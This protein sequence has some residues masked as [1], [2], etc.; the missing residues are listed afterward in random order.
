[1]LGDSSEFYT[2][3]AHLYHEQGKQWLASLPERVALCAAQWHVTDLSVS[4][5][6]SFNYI[7]M[8][9]RTTDN[10]HVVIKIAYDTD[11]WHQEKIMLERYNGNGCVRLLAYDTTHNALLLEQL[12]S[13]RPLSSLFPYQEN[14]AIEHTVTLMRQLH[15]APVPATD[16]IQ[17]LPTS[18]CWLNLLNQDMANIPVYHL[19]KARNLAQQLLATQ[20]TPVLVHGDLHQGNI[21]SDGNAWRAIDPK[22]AI[23]E[24]AYEV[25]A[26][27]RNPTQLLIEHPDAQTIIT[28]RIALFA[29][30]MQVDRQRIK[31]WSYVQ[32]VL[33]A[34]WRQQDDLE[35]DDLIRVAELIDAALGSSQRRLGSMHALG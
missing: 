25:G 18:R 24:P 14:L 1:M 4:P 32:A 16:Q 30:H 33:A 31:S 28:N 7:V 17:G 29:Q 2:T 13:A 15:A 27:I 21:L 35:T 23:G 3:I 10:T 20:A 9:Q 26:F 19:H 8:G 11:A 6:L 5:H 34:C 22:G 12:I